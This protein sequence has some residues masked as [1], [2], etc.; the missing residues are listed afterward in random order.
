VPLALTGVLEEGQIQV[1]AIMASHLSTEAIAT[2]NALLAIL[3]FLTS[4][5][6]AISSSTR[7][8][9]SYHLGAGDVPG[10]KQVIKIALLFG[11][12][13]GIVVACCFV[14]GRNFI[15]HIYSNDPYV[16]VSPVVHGAL[17]RL[18]ETSLSVTWWP[19]ML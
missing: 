4:A 15:G 17:P 2:H 14:F 9:V 6:W 19:P 16:W 13:F 1:V 7:V 8:R 12:G 11:S 10:A 5:M 3:W 18:W